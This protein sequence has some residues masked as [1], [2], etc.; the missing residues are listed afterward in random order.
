MRRLAPVAILAAIA[1]VAAGCGGASA[2]EKY[3]DGVCTDIR[4]WTG[5]LQ[6]SA[7]AVR[8][9]LK[10]PSVETPA[11]IKTQIDNAAAATTQLASE[12]K[13]RK[14]PSSES[15]REA[16][17]QLEQLGAQL[18]ATVTQAKHAVEGLPANASV[19]E[20]TQRLA[21][22]LPSLQSLASTTSTALEAV[23]ANGEKLKDGFEE[24]D[25]CKKL[26]G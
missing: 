7:D 20:I 15:G 5:Q 13:S 17:R 2:E 25:A 16:Q 21:V 18:E 9:E 26:R 22:L 6:K 11:A 10:S 23:K 14:P 12:L 24:A 3:A 8:S 19:T 4:D 1:F